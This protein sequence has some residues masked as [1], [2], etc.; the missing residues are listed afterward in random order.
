MIFHGREV[1]K[2]DSLTRLSKIIKFIKTDRIELTYD[3]E[4]CIE[5]DEYLPS[6]IKVM[7]FNIL[8]DIYDKQITNLKKRKDNLINFIKGSDSDIICLQEM[9]DEFYND[10][11]VFDDI[12][13]K[14]ITDSK[15][16]NIVML[17]KTNPS[18]CEIIDL[19]SR[20]SKKAL[21]LCFKINDI[22]HLTVVGI[23]LTSDTHKN[24]KSMRIQQISK[25]LTN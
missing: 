13:K 4:D 9:T 25:I 22:N 21:K 1:K 19:D 14:N 20:G 16:N 12:Y 2:I 5:E 3:I 6:T 23:H 8:S 15:T 7:T 11:S 24:S 10:L 17:S 18:K